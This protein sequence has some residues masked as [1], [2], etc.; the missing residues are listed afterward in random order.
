[1]SHTFNK[2]KD[3]GGNVNRGLL[4]LS[5]QTKDS[6]KGEQGDLRVTYVGFLNKFLLSDLSYTIQMG[7]IT[8][9]HWRHS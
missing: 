9:G 7:T 8:A 3:L 6:A 5:D 4:T 2:C 1:M